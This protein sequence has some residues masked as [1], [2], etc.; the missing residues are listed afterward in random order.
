MQRRGRTAAAAAL[1]TAA[2]P[3][4]TPADGDLDKKTMTKDLGL[5][6]S[7]RAGP[8]RTK[9]GKIRLVKE[10]DTKK[11]KAPAPAK[12]SEV[13]KNGVKPEEELK[14]A[15]KTKG[16]VIPAKFSIYLPRLS[17]EQLIAANSPSKETLP[18]KRKMR[19]DKENTI[20]KTW[21][22]N[23]ETESEEEEQTKAK[24]DK[25]ETAKDKTKP[26]LDVAKGI[27]E[28]NKTK[29]DKVAPAS[30]ISANAAT[31]SKEKKETAPKT[32]PAATSIAKKEEPKIA[33]KSKPGPASSKAK[34]GPATKINRTATAAASKAGFSPPNL[35]KK[36][37]DKA[38]NKSKP[39]KVLSDSEDTKKASAK[40]KVLP[41][42]KKTP[43]KPVPASVAT[44]S[45]IVNRLRSR[46]P[47]N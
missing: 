39:L 40:G 22:D 11:G 42:K 46:A 20:E 9:G 24:K 44:A 38:K 4:P 3:P 31:N 33:S 34:P 25:K 19:G 21:K 12:S 14:G 35:L 41:K 47:K 5:E 29:I 45:P 18:L 10:K 26:R 32:A 28:D 17:V 16:S 7:P 36:E 1:P 30:E 23:S 15:L 43:P 13:E 27:K 6:S 37:T 8:L 2:T